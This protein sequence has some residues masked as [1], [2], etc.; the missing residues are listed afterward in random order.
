MTA[1][2][3][4]STYA[5]SNGE[6]LPNT[7]QIHLPPRS[8]K[9]HVFETMLEETQNT[10][11]LVVTFC[12]CGG[13]KPH[14]LLYPRYNK[15]STCTLIVWMESLINDYYNGFIFHAEIKTNFIGKGGG[16]VSDMFSVILRCKFKKTQF[17]QVI[18]TPPVPLRFAF[19]FL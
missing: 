8:T 6:K 19:V 5:E 18:W 10:L 1:L 15:I 7:A 16:G 13:K 11:S 12:A 4:L 2:A 3:W 17:F 14:I 9:Q